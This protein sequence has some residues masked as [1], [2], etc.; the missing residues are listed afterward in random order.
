MDAF[1]VCMMKNLENINRMDPSL[2]WKQG[3][4]RLCEVVPVRIKMFFVCWGIFSKTL[5]PSDTSC[6]DYGRGKMGAGFAL[7]KG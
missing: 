1:Q 7:G 5:A 3:M 4:D 6:L 2:R